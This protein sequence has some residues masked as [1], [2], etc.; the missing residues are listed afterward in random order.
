MRTNYITG[1]RDDLLPDE[2]TDEGIAAKL[3]R[4]RKLMR[5]ARKPGKNVGLTPNHVFPTS[6]RDIDWMLERL[7][8]RAIEQVIAVDLTKPEFNVAVARVVIPGL[9]GPDDHEDYTP[10]ARARAIAEVQG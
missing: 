10:G 2:Y 7:T 9:E 8:R 4:A 3:L 5:A 6:E 1:S